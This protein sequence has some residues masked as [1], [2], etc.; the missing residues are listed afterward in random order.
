MNKILIVENDFALAE[1]LCG[2]FQNREMMAVSCGTIK[3]A[4]AM[5]LRDTFHVVILDENLPDGN[6]IDLL[7]EIK[8]GLPIQK[9]DEIS[10]IMLVPND[11]KKNIS[12]ALE[13]GADDCITKPFSTA[14]LKARVATQFKKRKMNFSFAACERFEATGSAS[15]KGISGEHMV[16]IG[17]YIFDFDCGKFMCEGKIVELSRTEQIL[18]RVLVENR[19]VVLK[20]GALMERIKTETREKMSERIL[21]DTVQMLSDKLQAKDY[22]KMVFGIGYFWSEKQK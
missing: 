21:A 6:G 11:S 18:L 1:K 13:Q 7:R 15:E 17:K 4:H 8:T 2:A 5:L 16:T 3:E 20:R 12:R 10:V 14:A 19:G 22:I 9:R